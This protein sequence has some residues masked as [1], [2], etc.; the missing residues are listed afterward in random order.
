[1]VLAERVW[2]LA[3]WSLYIR[4]TTLRSPPQAG[5]DPGP[6]YQIDLPRDKT[7]AQPPFFAARTAA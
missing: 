2:R 5:L 7:V 3:A 6:L 1:M 4:A